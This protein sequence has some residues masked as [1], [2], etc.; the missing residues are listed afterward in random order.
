[1]EMLCLDD[2]F[3][4]E[5]NVHFLRNPLE[6]SNTAVPAFSQ[7]NCILDPV[8]ST[9]RYEMMKLCTGTV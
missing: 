5:G 1:M 8:G 9:V 7:P 6:I 4:R 3:H 2:F